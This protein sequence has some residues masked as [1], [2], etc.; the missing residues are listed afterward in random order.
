[1]NPH[2]APNQLTCTCYQ[3]VRSS[4]PDAVQK[5]IYCLINDTFQT[6]NNPPPKSSGKRVASKPHP[7][8]GTMF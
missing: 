8:Q 3:L 5:C 4:E 2:E 6:T 7:D 1:M